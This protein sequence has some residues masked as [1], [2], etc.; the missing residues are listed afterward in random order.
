MGGEFVVLLLLVGAVAG[1]I[2]CAVFAWRSRLRPALRAALAVGIFALGFAAPLAIFA[3]LGLYLHS[4]SPQPIL[5]PAHQP[6]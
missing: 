3:M 2:A 5:A 1:G 4:T 6:N